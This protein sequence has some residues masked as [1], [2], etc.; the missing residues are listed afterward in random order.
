MPEIFKAIKKCSPLKRG[1]VEAFFSHSNEF[2]VLFDDSIQN[3]GF[4]HESPAAPDIN[5]GEFEAMK[6][7]GDVLGIFFGHDHI[8]SFVKNVEGI[9]LGYTQGCGFNTYGPGK[10]RGV[11]MFVIDENDTKHYETYTVTMKELCD[12]KP[13]KPLQEFVLTHAPTSVEQVKKNVLRVGAAA[14]TVAIICKVLK[15]I[16]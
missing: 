14:G 16:K 2:Y 15:K 9:D 11:R 1:A 3:G 12:F 6:E 8:N 10:D 13:S 4:M 5:N 7:K